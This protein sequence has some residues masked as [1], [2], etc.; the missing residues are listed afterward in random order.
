[1][2]STGQSKAIIQ[3]KTGTLDEGTAN[4]VDESRVEAGG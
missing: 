1:M 2:S 4:V 3:N